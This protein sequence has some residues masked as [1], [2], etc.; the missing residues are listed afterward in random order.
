MTDTKDPIADA[1]LSQLA[2]GKP[3]GSISPEEVARAVAEA[4]RNPKDPHDLWRKYLPAVK[5]QAVHPAR[6]R[7]IE[8]F[9]K[10]KPVDDPS[11][12]KGVARYRLPESGTTP[13]SSETP[14]APERP[15]I[16]ELP[17][18]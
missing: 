16:P 1:I 9:R 14:E 13:E 6:A 3:G 17:E 11:R 5:Q 8:L 2:F 18:A 10:G 4:K 7:Q 12:V 15:E